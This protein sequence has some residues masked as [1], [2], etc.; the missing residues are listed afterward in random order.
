MPFS[1]S[2][3]LLS[4]GL[5]AGPASALAPREPEALALGLIRDLRPA[6]DLEPDV[7]FQLRRSAPD[8][9]LGGTDVRV[10]QYY[11]G[12]RV[13]G[14]EAI[15]H[16][17]QGRLRN[18]TDGLRRRFTLDAR[19]TLT[20]SEALAIAAADLAPRGPFVR[21]P[22]TSAGGRFELR[23]PTRGAGGNKVVN[24]DHGLEDEGGQTYVSSSNQWGDGANYDGGSTTSANGETAAVDAAYGLQ[25]TWDYYK[26]IHHRDGIDGKNTATT[27]RVHYDLEYDN[28]F[29]NDDCFCMTFGDGRKFKSLEAM[30][31]IG[32]EVSHGVCSTTAGL[33]YFGESGGLN[34]ANSDINGTMVA[35]YARG[36]RLDQVG[37]Q[38]AAW[39]IGAQLATPLHPKP[40][41]F[42]YKPSLDGKS[43]DAWS[44]DLENLGVHR[45]S[46]P[47]NR[48]F[49]FLSQGASAKAPSPYATSYL[50]KGM[51]GIGNDKSARIWYRAMASYL[52]S[53]SNY[54]DARK[55]CIQAARDLYGA[56]G[57]EERAVWNAFHGIHVGE[58]WV[59]SEP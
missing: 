49:Y 56:G 13:M 26:N 53:L 52:T 1:K 32:H 54:A 25:W 5:L 14:G 44:E 3:C 31:V 51:H 20:P 21:P 8:P 16:L 30:D 10:D 7:T 39:T 55:A 42:M 40:V 15:V 34:E 17:R 33:E 57:P 37:D 58:P 36:G 46:G 59:A 18:L 11:R 12:V 45:S 43:P 38:G 48:C 23:D 47:M 28:A 4:A 41:R 6:L 24:L 27:L 22:T 2:L 9:A 50:P 35:F 29:W 19:P